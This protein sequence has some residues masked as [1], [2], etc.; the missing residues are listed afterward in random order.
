MSKMWFV[1]GDIVEQNKK[2]SHI[3]VVQCLSFGITKKMISRFSYF[4]EI[5]SK[6]FFIDGSVFV[7][8]TVLKQHHQFKEV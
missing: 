4:A 2:E 7:V 8:N 6:Y 1:V 3:H 5:F